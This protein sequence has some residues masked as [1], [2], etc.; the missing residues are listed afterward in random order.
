MDRFCYLVV[1]AVL[2]GT[3]WFAAADELDDIR[4]QIEILKNDYEKRIRALEERLE[5]AEA[6]AS[7]AR[8][9]A[10]AA[11]AIATE[12][13]QA[14]ATRTVQD[15]ANTF[16]PAVTAVLQGSLNSY[17][18]DP[19]DYALPGFQLGGEAGLAAEGLTLDETELMLSASV[20]QLFFAQ[21]TIALHDDGNETEVEVEEAFIDALAMPAGTGLRFGRFYSDIGYLNKVHTHAWDFRDAPLVYR[22]MLGKQYADDGIQ[23]SWVA[24][25]DLYMRVGGETLRG[26]RFPG[27]EATDTL[28]NSQSLFIKFGGD[29]GASHSWQ[30]GLSQLWVD[31]VDRDSS[32]HSHGGAES[33][34]D[35]F[36]GDSNLTIADFVWKWAPQG[37]P[38]NHNLIFQSEL[39]YRNEDGTDDFTESGDTAVLDYD[40]KQKGL[41]AQLVYQFMPQWRL[42]VRYDWLSS[43]NELRVVDAGG[44]DPNEVLEETALNSNDHDPNR[45]SLMA[46]W[47]PSE[48][49]RLRL[50]YN[51]DKSRPVVDNQWTL[52]Y[53]MSLGSHGVHEF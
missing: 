31:A 44:L 9:Q 18:R 25:T 26:D 45:W 10:E 52:Q 14:P 32:G 3:P 35:S 49:S 51:R 41:Y 4:N 8:Q 16:N 12:S 11:E 42:G 30:A 46:D 15:K 1:C 50:Q 19:D 34:G 23:L 2:W 43:D 6:D 53:I 21:T 5:K 47:S 20:D 17:S 36:T 37:N 27:G 29:V 48:F 7:D 33:T 24:P 39:F 38:G 28:G 22:A 40:G 13:A